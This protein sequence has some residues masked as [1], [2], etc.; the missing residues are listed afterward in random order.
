MIR[1]LIV[2]D[3][4]LVRGGLK[5][6]LDA[7]PDIDVVGEAEDGVQ[8]VAG[9]RALRPDVILLDVQMPKMNGLDAAKAILALPDIN[10]RVIMITTFDLDEYIYTAI[11]AGASGF[12]LKD[13]RAEVLAD[14]RG[15]LDHDRVEQEEGD[16]DDDQPRGD[17]PH[18]EGGEP[19]AAGCVAV[20]IAVV[21]AHDL[22][23]RGA[24]RGA[25]TM[26]W[27]GASR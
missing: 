17:G 9:A 13:T 7:Q 6:I 2:D 11:A 22:K 5:M 15:V 12:L 25:Q 21:D 10:P 14:A 1:V 23:C 16:V 20:I 4:H 19:P 18:A 26:S 24:R 3:E 8:A 27:G